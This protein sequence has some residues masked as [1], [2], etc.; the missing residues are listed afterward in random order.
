MPN[1]FVSI[2]LALL[3]SLAPRP[4]TAETIGGN[5]GP[6]YNYVCPHADGKPALDCYFDAVQHLYTMCRNVKFIEII[7]YGYEDSTK[8]TNGA[9]SESCLDK[10]KHNIEHPYKAALKAAGKSKELLNDLHALQESWLSAM[11]TLSWRTG[12]SKLDY[13]AR[14]DKPYEDFKTRIGAIRTSVSEAETKVA[15]KKAAKKTKP[16]KTTKPSKS[17]KPAKPPA[18]AKTATAQQH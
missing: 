17:S 1:A 13:M 3:A 5:P 12:E 16:A 14:V 2:L 15:E 6:A 11:S 7:E 10:Q 8:G 18:P 4:A 9:K